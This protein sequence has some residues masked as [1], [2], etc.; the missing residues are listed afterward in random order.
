VTQLQLVQDT[1][2]ILEQWRSH[3]EREIV[4]LQ[5]SKVDA[6]SNHRDKMT[7]KDQQMNIIEKKLAEIE[8]K[9]SKLIEENEKLQKEKKDFIKKHQEAQDEAEN[10]D[11]IKQSFEKQLKTEKMLKLQAVNKLAEVMNRKDLQKDSR[12]RHKVSSDAMK[13]KEKECRRLQA[14]LEKEKDKFSKLTTKYAEDLENSSMLYNEEFQKATDLQ[15][16]CDSKDGQLEVLQRQLQMLQVDVSSVCSEVVDD[17]SSNIDT[18][19]GWLSIPNKGNIKKIGYW[20]KQFVIVSKRKILFYD[21]EFEK[22]NSN[23]SM[24][25]DI[26]KL[27]HVRSVTQAEAY[28]AKPQEIPTIFQILYATEGESRRL[29]EQHHQSTA[30]LSGDIVQDKSTATSHKGHSFIHLVYHLPTNCEICPKPLWA[31]PMFRPPPAIECQRCHAKYHRDHLEMGLIDACKA[32]QYFEVDTKDLLIRASTSE[33]QKNWV[34]QLRKKI[35][36]KPPPPIDPSFGGRNSPRVASVRYASTTRKSN[37]RG[38]SDRIQKPII[39][40]SST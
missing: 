5:L 15:M 17:T 35:P 37:S 25:I 39:E 8:A 27:F 33:D 30:T 21:S 38:S 4:H 20:K 19:S 16:Q 31:M 1:N 13:K 32:N 7:D 22:N 6:E 2:T 24:V 9:N 18:L 10:L 12:N 36:K 11:L 23:P 29:P 40:K 28:R 3:Y 14:E 34:T 26:E